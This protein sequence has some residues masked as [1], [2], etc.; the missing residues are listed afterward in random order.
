MFKRLSRWT[1]AVPLALAL[2]AGL[3]GCGDDDPGPASGGSGKTL[4]VFA[5]ASLTESFT[6]LG[7]TFESAHPGVKLRFNFGSSATLA[8]QITQ[9][10]PADVFAAASPA[11]MKTVTDA[12]M[13]TAPTT[14]VRNKLQI[15][16]PA[17]NPAKVDDLKDLADPKVKVALCAAQ[18]PC[19]AAAAK[20]LEAAGLKVKPVTLEQDVKATLTKVE[21][22]EVDAALVYKTDVFA[23]GNKVQG[24]TFP[25]ADKA[26]NDYPIT[27][28]S[29]ASAADLAKQFVDLVLSAQGKSVMTK[30]GFETS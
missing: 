21:L 28:L 16:V 10:A 18:V 7:R 30:A 25:E 5:A 22:G 19:G 8:Q 26:I 4:T 13:A 20:A 3:S 1:T 23:A 17:D 15:A 9:G 2:V 11:T 27:A 29:K 12:S 24:I 14:F 6:E